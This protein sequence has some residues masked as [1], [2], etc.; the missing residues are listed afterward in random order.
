MTAVLKAPSFLSIEEAARILQAAK[1]RPRDYVLI[2]CLLYMGLR[3][4]ELCRLTKDQVDLA[5]GYVRYVGGRKVKREVLVP[6]HPALR[7]D[8]AAYMRTVRGPRLFPL[9]VRAVEKLVKRVAAEA[10]VRRRVWPHLFRHTFVTLLRKQG[11]DW[12]QIQALVGHSS[13]KV[14]MDFY[15]GVDLDE[16][17]RAVE[18][19][20]ALG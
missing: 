4:G 1:R 8:L 20:P 11:A 5:E 7:E 17:R 13:I 14:T 18:R 3:V 10:G 15:S 12:K 19:L 9:T 16:K 6:I 2:G